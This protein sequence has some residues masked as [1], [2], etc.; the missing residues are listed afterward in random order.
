VL[1]LV[2]KEKVL[3]IFRARVYLNLGLR[4]G[5]QKASRKLEYKS[6]SGQTIVTE[7][8]ALVDVYSCRICSAPGGVLNHSY[9]SAHSVL[10]SIL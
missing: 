4:R 7:G 5:L 2:L 10:T 6:E 8:L 3:A 1:E 9:R